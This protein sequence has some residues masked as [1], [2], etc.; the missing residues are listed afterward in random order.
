[1]DAESLRKEYDELIRNLDEEL[2]A[3]GKR[4][5]KL[6]EQ[7][8]GKECLFQDTTL[9]HL[10]RQVTDDA[11]RL[12]ELSKQVPES[13]KKE[14]CL[15]IYGFIVEYEQIRIDIE[16]EQ[17]S[18]EVDD[19]L[20]QWLGIMASL[21]ILVYSHLKECIELEL[22]AYSREHYDVITKKMVRQ[23]EN[24]KT[25]RADSLSS[26]EWGKMIEQERSALKLAVR[27]ELKD[28][29]QESFSWLGVWSRRQMDKER[30][31][32]KQMLDIGSD[33]RLFD[34][35]LMEKTG[36]GFSFLHRG[37]MGLFC[38]LFL[39]HNIIRCQL[40]PKLKEEFEGWMRG[41]YAVEEPAV[42][43][44]AAAAVQLPVVP[45]SSSSCSL[46]AQL[47]GEK[48]F[49][50]LEAFREAGFLD[51]DYR[52]CSPISRTERALLAYELAARLEIKYMWS[53][54]TDFWGVSVQS[55]DYQKAVNQTTKGDYMRSLKQV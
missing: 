17:V 24:F 53:F 55:S 12:D 27:G 43:P 9:L 33:E 45:P 29:A 52:P 20:Q 8:D 10:L 5:E 6:K 30:Y 50:V 7:K 48:A 22:V 14:Y 21:I 23:A 15:D 49:G 25:S 1:M 34:L 41:D 51:A 42:Q 44:S 19:L 40:H 36:L 26:V 37:N 18:S 32:M 4:L 39:R 3:L 54:F 31:L 47:Q 11:R 38:E 13:L 46:P 28:A 35:E 16:S 2:Y